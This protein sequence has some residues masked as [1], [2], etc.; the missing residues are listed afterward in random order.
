[1]HEKATTNTRRPTAINNSRHQEQCSKTARSSVSVFL[2]L[3]R[4]S[5][6][7]FKTRAFT[8]SFEHVI[9]I[10]QL[11]HKITSAASQ[12]YATKSILRRLPNKPSLK[13]P[14]LLISAAFNME[15]LVN[16]TSQLQL[17]VYF[18]RDRT[19]SPNSKKSR[20]EQSRKICAS[21]EMQIVRPRKRR[22]TNIRLSRTIAPWYKHA[23]IKEKRL[24]TESQ[25]PS[26]ANRPI[27]SYQYSYS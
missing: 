11:Q 22:G 7:W 6:E 10:A 16:A 12:Q 27:A 26:S 13:T 14:T 18:A 17:P 2:L 9:F 3:F 20:L 23:A 15:P 25:T 24:A 4:N 19:R 21:K 8:E 5:R 1:M